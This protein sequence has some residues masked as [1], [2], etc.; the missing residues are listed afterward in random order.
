MSL[1][2]PQ[3]A[4]PAP[5]GHLPPELLIQIFSHLSTMENAQGT[6]HSST[7]VSRQWYSSAVPALYRSPVITGKNFAQFVRTLCPSVNSRVKRNG[8][9]EMVRRLDM[10]ALVHD[11]S[12]SVT[13]RM[14]RRCQESLE[15]FMAPKAS[16]AYVS[17][18]VYLHRGRKKGNRKTDRRVS[19]VY[20]NGGLQSGIVSIRSLRC[21]NAP[22]SVVWISR[23]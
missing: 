10:S 22:I 16:F 15:E 18:F 4:Y 3:Q 2:D 13:A 5:P 8:L 23:S 9:A 19:W 14:L 7:L 12:R 17:L 20:T 6:L 1:P 21:R 11:G